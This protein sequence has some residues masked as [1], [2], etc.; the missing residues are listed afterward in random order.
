MEDNVANKRPVTAGLKP[1]VA[2]IAR[3]AARRVI[4]NVGVEF[5]K[6]LIPGGTL[7][8]NISTLLADIVAQKAA[9]LIEHKLSPNLNP[10]MRAR[11]SANRLFLER[12]DVTVTPLLRRDV[13]TGCVPLPLK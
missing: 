6:N 5:C 10:T 11:R 7:A 9:V 4:P 3:Q 13:I 12:L 2:S 8:Y 1:H